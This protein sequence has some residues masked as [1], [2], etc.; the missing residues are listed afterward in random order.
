MEKL[1]TVKEAAKFLSA[2]PKNLYRLISQ[3]RIPFIRKSGIG[4]RIRESDL[5]RWL[6]EGFNP[7]SG[8][9]DII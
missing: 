4:Y 8:W 7:P 6:Q 9:K 5:M 2:N 3:R 1:L